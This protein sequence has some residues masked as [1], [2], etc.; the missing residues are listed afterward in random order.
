MTAGD[1]ESLSLAGVAPSYLTSTLALASGLGCVAGIAQI[2]NQE[3]A[4]LAVYASLDGGIGMDLASILIDM[5]PTSSLVYGQLIGASALSGLLGHQIAKRVGPT[6]LPQAVAGF[7]SLVGVAAAS[8][9]SIGNFMIHSDAIATIP[10]FHAVSTYLGT[11]MGG[12][13]ATDSL[14]AFGKLAEKLDNKLLQLPM[15]EIQS[16]FALSG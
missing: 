10:P 7:H 11:W 15:R 12:I 13:T 8:T 4:R 16:T 9:D 2:S 5:A 6:E 3:T 14:I 1:L